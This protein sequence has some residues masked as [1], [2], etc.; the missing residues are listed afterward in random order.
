MPT[1]STGPVLRYTADGLPVYRAGRAPGHLATRRQ[2]RAARL[3]AA[4]L[5]PAGWLH[6]NALHG[7]CPLYDQRQARPVRP[8]TA[9][10]AAALAAGRMMRGRP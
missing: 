8:L 6:Y 3:S 7:W 1:R 2:L 5:A 9:R 10:Q 4:G